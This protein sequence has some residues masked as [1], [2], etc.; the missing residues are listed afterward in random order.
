MDEHGCRVPGCEAKRIGR[1]LCAKHYSR[2]TCADAANR[3]EAEKYVLPPAGRWGQPGNSGSRKAKPEAPAGIVM[4]KPLAAGEGEEIL[5][6]RKLTP[7]EGIALIN[8]VA[9]LL[10]MDHANFPRLRLLINPHSGKAV[11]INSAGDLPKVQLAEITLRADQALSLVNVLEL[12]D[13]PAVP[14]NPDETLYSVPG[15]GL[16]VIISKEG[17]IF[18][19]SI[20]KG[21]AVSV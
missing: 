18:P 19:A 12:L 5:P 20:R 3:T 15:S 2:L 16:A 14:L 21:D 10:G 6:G 4:K 17:M 1:G 9:T 11:A 7:D 8:E 13:V